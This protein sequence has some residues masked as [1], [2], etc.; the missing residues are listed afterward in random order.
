M[1]RPTDPVGHWE[2]LEIWLSAVT[3]SLLPKAAEAVKH[4][5]QD[6]LD[7]NITGIMKHDPGQS[8]GHKELA[9]I[10]GSLSH[11]LIASLKQSDRQAA[12]LQQELKRAQRRI[13]QLEL[14]AQ[15]RREG[16]NETD[17]RA[18]EEIARLQETL[19]NN[20]QEMEQAKSAR[21]ELSGELQYAEQLL[22]KARLDFR[23]KNSRI[24]ALE[25]HLN[26]ARTE[27]SYLTQ[28]LD[29]MKEVF[30]SVKNELRH[31]YE[32]R[33]EPTRTQRKKA[34]GATL[35]PSPAPSEETYL[36]PKLRELPKA[37]HNP[38]HGMDLKDLDK[39]ARNISKFTPSVPDGQ[40]VHSYLNDVDFHLEMRPNVTDKDRLYLLRM[41]SSPEVRSFL[42][43][44]PSHTKADY[45][46]LRQA[47]VKEF[48]V[49]ESEQG[50]VA[51]LETKQG[52]HESSQAYYSR[53]REAYF[54]ARN[55]PDMEQDMNFKT[56]FLR[57]LHPAVSHHLGVLA[58][59]QTMTSQQLRDLAHK[60][61]GKQKM[62]SEKGTKSTAVLDF[63]T[64]CQEM[65]LEGAQ[66]Q[67]S[68]KPPPREWRPSSFNRE[69][70]F[71]F[72]ARPTQRNNRWDGPRGRQHS[73][74]RYWEKSW[75]HPRPCENRWERSWSQP[76]SSGSSRNGLWESN[77]TI[78][79][80]RRKNLQRSHTD[81]A[82]AESTHEEETL[83]CFD[84]QE[85]MK[86]MMQE[87]FKRKKE[88]RKWEKKEKPTAA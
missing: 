83:P 41:R 35:K 81:Q 28:Q 40:D 85:L 47:L 82:Q 6:Q 11:T 20:T 84:S 21:A 1:P 80:N 38:S 48:A 53:L 25:T 54:G 51:A 55:E 13:E 31:A 42:D 87:F 32:L 66:H 36:T 62:A 26:E 7:N 70:D 74:E 76:T 88:D 9:K 78:P 61:Y 23:D 16:S 33:P 19:A 14:E 63:N 12:Y 52:R 75:Y 30:D 68:F 49:P 3:D 39:L 18:T 29:D 50:L 2:D 71:H 65:T 59:P 86:M 8:Y 64:Q 56:L 27:I 57:N 43:R 44:Q 60:A 10:T 77:A 4:Q 34:E 69:R 79:T 24:K 45:Q 5:T 58:C 37:S 15:D 17:P 73:P 72:G 67:E 22:E 46:S